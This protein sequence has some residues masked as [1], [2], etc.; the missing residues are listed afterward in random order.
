MK[1]PRGFGDGRTRADRPAGGAFPTA[2]RPAAEQVCTSLAGIHAAIALIFIHSKFGWP[3]ADFGVKVS[4]S[5]LL[6]SSCFL[7]I[8]IRSGFRVSDFGF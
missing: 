8:G 5:L 6:W 4:F 2:G 3:Q 1:F 7:V